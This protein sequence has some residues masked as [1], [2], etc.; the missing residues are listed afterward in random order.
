MLMPVH[1][2]APSVS[3]KLTNMDQNLFTE[4]QPYIFVVLGLIALVFSAFWATT[5]RR[6]KQTGIPVDGIVFKQ[7]S[8]NRSSQ[9]FDNSLSFTKDKITIKFVTQT[10]EWIT[11]VLKQ[12]FELF[13]TGQYKDGDT[14]KV[15]YDK[16]NPSDFY[17]DTKQSEFTG[18]LI[19]ALVGLVFLSIGPYKLFI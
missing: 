11:G 12:D 8:D 4:Y 18:R 9:S 7:D 15:Y 5:K 10:G 3:G 19:F 2:Q 1:R 16:S 6:L 17:V 13:Y 14:V